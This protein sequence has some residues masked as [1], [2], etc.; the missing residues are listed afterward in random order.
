M[1]H[2]TSRE[3]R[4]HFL[5]A[6]CVG[7]GFYVDCESRPGFAAYDAIMRELSHLE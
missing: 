6:V 7:A 5:D 2:F 4:I 3:H 1:S